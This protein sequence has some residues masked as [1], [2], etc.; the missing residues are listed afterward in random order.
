MN[1]QVKLINDL[2][3]EFL[4]EVDFESVSK[5]EFSCWEEALG[6]QETDKLFREYGFKGVRREYQKQTGIDLVSEE[7]ESRR[8]RYDR[9]KE[10]IGDKTLDQWGVMRLLQMLESKA[11]DRLL[12]LAWLPQTTKIDDVAQK[13]PDLPESVVRNAKRIRGN[14]RN[15]KPEEKK[16]IKEAFIKTGLHCRKAKYGELNV[17]VKEMIKQYPTTN[18]D[19]LRKHWIVEWREEATMGT[20]W[21]MEKK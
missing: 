17:F 9:L 15:E 6:T 10:L 11:A 8:E 2:V 3:Y 1:D 5:E 7:P 13:N 19:T 18:E 21:G 20:K 14:S 16:I 4:R 12:K